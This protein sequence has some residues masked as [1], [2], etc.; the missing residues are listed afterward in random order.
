MPVF[1]SEKDAKLPGRTGRGTV[2]LHADYPV[3]YAE[4]G[5]EVLI[6]I[7]DSRAE[8]GVSGIAIMELSFFQS[9]NG[10]EHIL[11][12]TGIGGKGVG[13]EL[14]EIHDSVAAHKP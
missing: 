3:A 9:R 10:A 2:A 1:C 8:Q 12:G 4:N 11:A 6:Y 7:H 13:L 5:A 14:A